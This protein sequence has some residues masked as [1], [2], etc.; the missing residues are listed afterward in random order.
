MNNN[1]TPPVED[2]DKKKKKRN[3]YYRKKKPKTVSDKDS[4]DIY[5]KKMFTIPVDQ[6]PKIEKILDHIL[7]TSIKPEI[8]I[9]TPIITKTFK[10]NVLKKIDVVEQSIESIDDLILI[11]QLYEQA[12]FSDKNYSINVKGLYEMKDVLIELKS[13]VGLENIKKDIIEFIIFFSQ[14]LH[15]DVEFKEINKPTQNQ[16]NGLFQLFTGPPPPSSQQQNTCS[17]N[18]NDNVLIGDSLNDLKHMVIIGPPGCGKTVLARIIAKICLHLGICINDKFKVVKRQ[19]LIG[20]YLGHTAIKTQKV[21]DEAY[22]GVLFIDEAYSLG[23]RDKNTDSFSKECIDTLNQ[24]LTERKGEFICI[25]A[26]Y[27][28]ELETNFFSINPGLKRRFPFVYKIEKYSSIQLLEIL[29][30]KISL[31]EWKIK[32]ETITWIKTTDYFKD[33]LDNFPHYAGDIETLLFNIKIEH[34]KRVFGK[35][36]YLHKCITNDDINA[37]YKRYLSHKKPKKTHY[38]GM[39]L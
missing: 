11:G 31:I 34:G 29:L 23:N 1:S 7:I 8:Q 20:E 13:L 10:P 15:R 17:Y 2:K 27:E 6:N 5:V 18:K 33:K 28:E 25:I 4:T 37:G 30:L 38:A 39:Y 16:N 24:N 35:H 19:D 26:G 22:G 12:E 9:K 21:I 3:N 36:L 32:K 14:G